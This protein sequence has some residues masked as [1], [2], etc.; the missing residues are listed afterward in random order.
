MNSL[1]CYFLNQLPTPRIL[2]IHELDNSP[3][4]NPPDAGIPCLPCSRISRLNTIPFLTHGDF[5][6]AIAIAVFRELSSSLRGLLTR[7]RALKFQIQ[8][9]FKPQRNPPSH[10]F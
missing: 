8:H 5:N 1:N 7:S 10:L 3:D 6:V 2:S 4:I 9:A